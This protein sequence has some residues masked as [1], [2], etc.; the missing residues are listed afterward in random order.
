MVES[1][2]RA[3]LEEQLTVR[4]RA[5]RAADRSDPIRSGGAPVLRSRQGYLRLAPCAQ[6]VRNRCAR[7]EGDEEAERAL[8]E[9]E[10]PGNLNGTNQWG[11]PDNV[12]PTAQQGNSRVYTLRRLKRDHPDLA[13]LVVRSSFTTSGPG[14]TAPGASTGPLRR[15]AAAL[16]SSPPL[17]PPGASCRHDRNDY[18]N[19]YRSTT[20]PLPRSYRT[21]AHRGAARVV[22]EAHAHEQKPPGRPDATATATATAQRPRAIASTRI[23]SGS[24]CCASG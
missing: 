6:A 4:P 3:L 21:G 13:A 23:G 11:G 8:D 19:D 17:H 15:R 18:R 10:L 5:G 16:W 1:R 2:T 9:A 12:I 20:A 24:R 22:R 7:C 14:T